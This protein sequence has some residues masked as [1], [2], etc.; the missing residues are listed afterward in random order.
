MCAIMGYT[1]RDI[2]MSRLA[3]AFAAAK[4]RGPDDS[5]TLEAGSGSLLFHRLAI[6]GAQP[7]G[8]QPFTAPAGSGVACSGEV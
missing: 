7:E 1:E 6:R 8:V 2:P 4:S 3:A 5:R